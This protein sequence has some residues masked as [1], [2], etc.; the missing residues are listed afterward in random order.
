MMHRPD[1]DGRGGEHELGLAMLRT[2]RDF[3]SRFIVALLVVGFAA[4][5]FAQEHPGRPGGG[6]ERRAEQGQQGGQG[7]PN[8]SGPGVLSLLPADSVT[9]HSIATPGGKLKGN[10]T[11]PAK[12]TVTIDGLGLSFEVEGAVELE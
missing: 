2:F 10:E 6:G 7:R 4:V 9:Q 8:Q 12:A 1:G 5:S 3:G 11:L